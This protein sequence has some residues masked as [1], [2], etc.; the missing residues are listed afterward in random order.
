MTRF[1]MYLNECAR[2]YSNRSSK[3]D[4]IAYLVVSNNKANKH[5]PAVTTLPIVYAQSE[6]ETD[7]NVCIHNVG[8]VDKAVVQCSKPTTIDKVKL[9]RCI[10]YL[11][12]AETQNRV[13]QAMRSH[14][15]KLLA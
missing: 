8:G 11:K 2:Q 7:S 10:G 5:S 6:E 9:Q 4:I 12:D 3:D 14:I 1:E 15:A 13:N